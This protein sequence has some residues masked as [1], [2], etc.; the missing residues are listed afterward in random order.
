MRI[1]I[2]N[3]GSIQEIGSK[4]AVDNPFRILLDLTFPYHYDVPTISLQQPYV[5]PIPL[6]ISREL[7]LPELMIVLRHREIAYRT[8]MPEAPID[9]DSHLPA[10]VAD[11][12]PSWNLPLE[13]VSGITCLTQEFAELHLRFRILAYVTPHGLHSML[14]QRHR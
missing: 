10:R 6:D 3:F 5:A 8:T 14:V 13:T 1:G 12:R 7:G 11:I 9:E 4:D 2:L